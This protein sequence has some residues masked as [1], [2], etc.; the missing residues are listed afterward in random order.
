VVF[1]IFVAFVSASAAKPLR[2]DQ[3]SVRSTGPAQCTTGRQESSSWTWG[4]PD[5]FRSGT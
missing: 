2:R 4:R 3:V 5:E 1:V